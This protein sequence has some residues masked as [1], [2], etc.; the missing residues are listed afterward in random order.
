[1]NKKA[2][3]SA[4]A[5]MLLALGSVSATAQSGNVQQ[6]HA[7]GDYPGTQKMRVDKHHRN[8]AQVRDNRGDHRDQR[9]SRAERR[10][11]PPRS[12]A[13]VR[14][15]GPRHD[16]YRGE[17]LP[18]QYRTRYYVVNDWHGHRLSRPP[19]GYQWVQTGADYVL[20]GTLSGIIAQIVL[21]R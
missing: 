20:I 4:V 2:L 12:H 18:A 19:R 1:M 17:R 21:A 7:Q 16:F 13:G 14:G 15:A 8:D 5:A 9:D 10:G 6:R 11:P 3:V